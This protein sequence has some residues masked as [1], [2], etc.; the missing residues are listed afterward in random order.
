MKQLIYNGIG[1][2]SKA[3]ESSNKVLLVCDSSFPYLSIKE[4]IEGMNVPFVKFSDFTPNPLYEDVCKGVD[5]FH[6]EQCDTILAV[7]GGSSMDV[8]KCIKLYSKMSKDTLYLKQE[9][10]DTGVKLIAIPTTAGTGSESTRYAVIYYDGK[11][12][13]VTHD[14]IIPNI[15]ILEPTVLKTLPLYQKKCTM[16]DAYC[17][18]IE[19]WW[20]VNSTDESKELSKKAVETITRW[21]R[22]YI[23]E[24]TDESAAA[25]MEAANLAGQAICITQTTAAHAFSY[26]ITSLYH[27]PHGHAVAVGLPVIWGYM[28]NNMDKCIDCRGEEYLSGVFAQISRAMGIT[29]GAVNAV[30]AFR[31]ML[32]AMEIQ[33][34]VSEHRDTDL[35]ILSNSVNPIRL[36]NNP[37]E[38][39]VPT[40]HRLYETIVK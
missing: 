30:T 31:L 16:L 37:V 12:Q 34:P 18:G 8:A 40:I 7:G 22:E 5:L 6:A 33:N 10:K 13:S 14:S 32:D 9:Y 19:S 26:K 36:K 21:W 20:S 23:F 25:I 29:T 28:I 4:A 2:L 3:L 24:N 38:L 17:Q 27:L 11:K 35:D 39:D 15:A 1:C